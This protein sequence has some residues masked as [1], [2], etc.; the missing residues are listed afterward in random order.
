MKHRLLK[1]VEGQDEFGMSW[2]RCGTVEQFRMQCKFSFTNYELHQATSTPVLPE[3][4]QKSRSVD[5][6][7]KLHLI[8]WSEAAGIYTVFAVSDPERG[9]LLP[10]GTMILLGKLDAWIA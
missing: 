6:V 9:E 10:D 2:C 8:Y 1:N 4:R 5:S 3:L 7:D